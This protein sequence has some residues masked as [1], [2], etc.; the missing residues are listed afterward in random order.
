MTHASHV[1]TY[2]LIISA[3]IGAGRALATVRCAVA[4][5]T[6]LTI[7]LAGATILE[8]QYGRELAQWLVYNSTWFSLLVGLIGLN[9]VA[10]AASNNA[11]ARPA[12]APAIFRKISMTSPW[13]A[14]FRNCPASGRAAAARQ[15]GNHTD[16]LLPRL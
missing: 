7:V 1:R 11:A 2:R 16:N 5:L 12:N 15:A 3:L 6:L 10:G 8:A 9:L 4:L 14:V 13:G